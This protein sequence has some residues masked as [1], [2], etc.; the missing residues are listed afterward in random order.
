MTHAEK[1][2][3]GKKTL[4]VEVWFVACEKA[5]LFFRVFDGEK[6]FNLL[7][8]REC[9]SRIECD[10]A[11]PVL[12]PQRAV[13]LEK[14]LFDRCMICLEDADSNIVH[15]SKICDKCCGENISLLFKCIICKKLLE[16]KF[17]YFCFS[18]VNSSC[19]K[20]NTV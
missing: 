2:E 12:R 10:F 16:H 11:Q 17:F 18:F 5:C 14:K 20:L 7:T 1:S 6:Y 8:N 3:F 19:V 4:E 9:V 15:C 13:A